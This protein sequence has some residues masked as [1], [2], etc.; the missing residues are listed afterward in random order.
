MSTTKPVL[1]I[2]GNPVGQISIEKNSVSVTADGVKTYGQ[3]LTSISSN[4][5]F[6]KITHNAKLVI[7]RGSSALIYSY[8]YKNGNSYNFT[9]SIE[10]EN[11]FETNRLNLGNTTNEMSTYTTSSGFTPYTNAT[12]SDGWKFT[13]YY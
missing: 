11:G 8:C 9:Y 5:D 7:D 10:N 6:S 12:P 3:V 2:N 4:A 1:L 13:L